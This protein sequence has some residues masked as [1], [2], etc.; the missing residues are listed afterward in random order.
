[1]FFEHFHSKVIC[2][3]TRFL[4]GTQPKLKKYLKWKDKISKIHFQIT[5]IFHLEN[6]GSSSFFSFGTKHSYNIITNPIQ[7]K[8]TNPSLIP[9]TI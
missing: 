5:Y 1:M 2:G 8:I 7:V 6:P 9:I 3:F 4:Q